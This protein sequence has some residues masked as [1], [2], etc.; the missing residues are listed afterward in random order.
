MHHLVERFF[1]T[2]FQSFVDGLGTLL[3]TGKI[4]NTSQQE[5]ESHLS[6]S[7][8]AMLKNCW[9]HYNLADNEL[10]NKHTVLNAVGAPLVFRDFSKGS[11][12]LVQQLVDDTI[13]FLFLQVL[14]SVLQSR[15]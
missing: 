6:V 13:F 15:L 1:A 14:E 11:R 10:E 2:F 8:R 5:I 4:Q 3:V 9:I 12:P 7:H